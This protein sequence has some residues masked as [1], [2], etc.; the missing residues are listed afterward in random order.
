MSFGKCRQV[1]QT[2]QVQGHVIWQECML[3]ILQDGFDWGSA[4]ATNQKVLSIPA[5]SF[6]QSFYTT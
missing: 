3:L 4:G 6:L 5:L 2:S 1:K